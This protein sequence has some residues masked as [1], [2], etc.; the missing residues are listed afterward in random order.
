MP[1]QEMTSLAVYRIADTAGSSVC[2]VPACVAA[3]MC[4]CVCPFTHRWPIFVCGRVCRARDIR[5]AVGLVAHDPS[6]CATLG[7]TTRRWA[8]SR[9]FTAPD[10]AM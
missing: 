1:A 7:S 9:M 5:F 3:V 10:Q 4:S 2:T 8:V 6:S